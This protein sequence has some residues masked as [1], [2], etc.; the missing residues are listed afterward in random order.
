MTD[1]KKIL[2]VVLASTLALGVS[3]AAAVAEATDAVATEAEAAKVYLVPGSYTDSATGDTVYHAV[4]ENVTKLTA[5]QCAEISTPNAYLFE[6]KAGDALPAPST[7]REGYTFNGWWCVENSVLVYHETM[8]DVAKTAYY[9]ADWRAELS[10]PMKPVNPPDDAEE[11]LLHYLHIEHQDTGE[12][13]L[14]PLFISGTD[15]SGACTAG[16]GG[17]VQFYNEWFELRANDLVQVWVSNIYGVSPVNAPQKRGAPEPKCGFDLERSGSNRTED[18]I[19]PYNASG[20]KSFMDVEN[21][22]FIYYPTASHHFRIY[23]KFYDDG[24]HMTI[25][26]ECKD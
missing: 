25:Y 13:E 8:P 17:P 14:V 9:Y 11:E 3:G 21:P 7:K 15:V 20:L 6:G 26:M 16:Y 18:F 4:T 12:E 2:A 10:Q 5:E 1:T 19:S 22:T 24:G 23:I